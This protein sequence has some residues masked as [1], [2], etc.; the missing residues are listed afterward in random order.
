MV[1]V[2]VIEEV[3]L[4]GKDRDDLVGCGKGCKASLLE[5]LHHVGTVVELV[6]RSGVKVGAKLREGLLVAVCGKVETQ[7]ASNLLHG[8]VLGIA[9]NPGDRDAHVHS[10]ALALEEQVGL[11][12]NLTI[13]DGNH[14]GGDVGG[15]VTLLRLDDGKR[16]KRA[17]AV[18]VGQLACALEETRVQVEDV[19][20]VSLTSRRTV[21]RQRHLTVSHSLLGEVIVDHEDVRTGVRCVCGVS[22]SIV[23]H[24]VLADGRTGHGGDVL[25]R[26]GVCGG[27]GHDDR[28]AE[29]TVLCQG[30]P[31]RGNRGGLLANGNV[32]TEH[33]RIALVHDCVDGNGGLARLT[34]ANDELTLATANGHHSIDGKKAGEHG[35]TDGL[36]C[37]DARGLELD[38]PTV[39]GI[40]GAKSVD[41]L[42][43]WVHHAAEHGVSHGDVHDSSGRTALV[44]LLDGVDVAKED[45][46]NPVLLEVLRQAIDAAAR[47]RARELQKL[48]SHGGLEARNVC[49]AVANLRDDRCLLTVN[50]RVDGGKLLAQGAH[51]ALGTNRRVDGSLLV[52]CHC[53]SPPINAEESVFLMC[54]SWARTEASMRLPRASRRTPP[55]ML[56]STRST[57]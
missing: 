15:D 7:R 20:R 9:A 50:R 36:S 30:L 2:D 44:A 10:G 27:G 16:R 52:L 45:G 5:E 14:V 34:I 21:Q 56:G 41:G 28:L 6:L 32:D 31:D 26:R 18:L 4:A 53:S 47:H 23:V 49:D 3:L 1:E 57:R 42:T 8:L 33:V 38:G 19:A 43:Q 24:E 35:L 13:G 39:R 25:K 12:V 11:Q 48:A 22:V 37:H 17:A 29:N 54:E 55:R 40:D 46:T 51:N